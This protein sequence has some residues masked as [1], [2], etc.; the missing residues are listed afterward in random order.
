MNAF[1]AIYYTGQSGSGNMSLLL[2]DGKAIGLEASG[3]IVRGNY[4]MAE[5]G[6]DANLSFNFIKG[7]QLVTGQSLEEDLSVPFSLK[8]SNSVLN[9]NTQTADMPIGR[10]NFRMEKLSDL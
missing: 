7:T 4:E 10:V 8:I 2:Q 1:Y 3:G 6:I 5:G 9:G